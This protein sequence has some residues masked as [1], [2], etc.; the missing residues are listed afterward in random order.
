MLLPSNHL[1]LEYL[2]GI[3]FILLLNTDM[4]SKLKFG[5]DLLK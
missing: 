4:Y 1:K 3:S 5:F 2:Y